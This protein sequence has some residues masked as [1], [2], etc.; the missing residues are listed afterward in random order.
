MKNFGNLMKQAQEMQ[1]KMQEMQDRL[2]DVA[3]AGA[4]GAGMVAVTLSGKGDMRK[5]KID[6]SLFSVTEPLMTV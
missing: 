4:A 5:V 3:I 2:D 6:P 1:A